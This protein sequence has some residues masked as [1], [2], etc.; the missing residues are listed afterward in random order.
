MEESLEFNLHGIFSNSCLNFAN[1]DCSGCWV[2][3]KKGM[4]LGPKCEFYELK[5]LSGYK[6]SYQNDS[7][8]QPS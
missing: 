1:I 7:K 5:D 4:C 3:E 6:I 8:L 2:L